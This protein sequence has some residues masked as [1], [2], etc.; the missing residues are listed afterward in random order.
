V[1]IDRELLHDLVRHFAKSP[2]VAAI[3][4][5]GSMANGRSKPDSDIDL[6][7]YTDGDLLDLR[8]RAL[9]EFADP[10]EWSAVGEQSFG[11]GDVWRL[12]DGGPWLDLMYRTR[13]WAEEQLRLVFIDHRPRIGYS[14]AFWRSIRDAHAL[15]E[16]DNWHS[17]LQARAR[18]PYPRELRVNI[19][20]ANFPYLGS[21]PFSFRNQL[22]KAI[23]RNDSVSIEHRIT[24]WLACYFDVLFA[25]NSVPHPG[26]KEL[27]D[28]VNRDCKLVPAE[29]LPGVQLLLA[30]P[31]ESQILFTIDKLVDELRDLLL[32][33]HHHFS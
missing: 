31:E 4:V 24:A 3:A 17:D 6:F 33:E 32:Q 22:A 10:E 11:D 21:H 12:K 29:F 28:W 1:L 13:E 18:R 27:L 15:Y 19:I 30:R 26:E 20:N 8:A 7:I 25:I 5:V 2:R 14:T 23:H 16:R 9:A